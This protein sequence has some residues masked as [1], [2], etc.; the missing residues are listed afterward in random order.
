M[1]VVAEEEELLDGIIPELAEMTE[2]DT[3]VV[4][5]LVTLEELMDAP[6]VVVGTKVVD[7][8]ITVEDRSAESI[9]SLSREVDGAVLEVDEDVGNNRTTSGKL[10]CTLMIAA[11]VIRSTSLETFETS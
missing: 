5:V 10:T 2:A 7:E 1:E 9:F 11:S 8:V 6:S 3:E 4:T